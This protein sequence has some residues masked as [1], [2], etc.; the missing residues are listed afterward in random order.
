MVYASIS[1]YGGNKKVPFS[2]DD[3]V[4]N[5]VSLYAAAKKSNELLAHAYSKLY[6]ISSTDLRFFTVYGLAGCP[7]M[8]N[9]SVTQKLV[10][11]VP[12]RSS[13]MESASAISL[14]LM[15]S[16][17]ALYGWWVAH[18]RKNRR[19]RLAIATLFGV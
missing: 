9:F 5:P 15:T 17:K 18:R 19:R 16:S 11:V 2:E 7:D 12:Y 1:V 4:S 3:K 14:I 8:F 10:V 6:N 13:I